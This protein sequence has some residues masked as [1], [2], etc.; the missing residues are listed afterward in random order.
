MDHFANIYQLKGGKNPTTSRPKQMKSHHH[1]LLLS[2]IFDP[3]LL[4]I[5][6]CQGVKCLICTPLPLRALSQTV[7]SG[8]HCALKLC[9]SKQKLKDICTS[10]E[11]LKHLLNFPL[12]HSNQHERCCFDFMPQRLQCFK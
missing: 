6:C 11:E 8:S 4:K 3:Y 12:G 2:V 7:W 1:S 9:Q 5:F 10:Q